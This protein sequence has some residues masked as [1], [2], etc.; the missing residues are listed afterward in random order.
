MQ[1]LWT[2]NPDGTKLEGF[3][4]NRSLTPATFMDAREIPGSNGKILCV[5]TSHSGPCRGAIGIVDPLLGGNA[6]NAIVNLTPE[7]N[8]G[9]VDAGGLGRADG[10]DGNSVRGPYLNPYPLDGKFYLVSKAGVVELRDYKGN[11]QRQRRIL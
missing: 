5:L 7:I 9:R 2:I 11:I 8:I 6:Q 1:S 3:F 4:G 10:G